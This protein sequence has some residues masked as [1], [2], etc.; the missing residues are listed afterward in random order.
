[1]HGAPRV[2]G[3]KL[4][5]VALVKEM[6]HIERKFLEGFRAAGGGDI[7]EY[8]YAGCVNGEDSEYG[9]WVDMRSKHGLETPEHKKACFC[10]TKIKYNC[11]IFHPKTKRVF[12]VG[13]ECINKFKDG[14]WKRCQACDAEY[15][16]VYKF[17]K[18]CLATVRNERKEAKKELGRGDRRKVRFGKYS[19]RTFREAYDSDASYVT[20][21]L[22]LPNPTWAQ[23][24][25]QAYSRNRRMIEQT[26]RY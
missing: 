3:I 23:G 13:S 8:E 19:G 21:V 17:C 22:G 12:V 26:L 16:G 15:A 20:W 25:F 4:F 9:Y 2:P 6:H 14:L 1:M 18:G 5:S 24:C 11:A 7:A 10:E